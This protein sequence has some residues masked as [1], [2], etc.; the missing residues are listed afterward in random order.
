MFRSSYYD[1]KIVIYLYDNKLIHPITDII[2]IIN[3]YCNT[4][5]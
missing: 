1:L 4:K 3:T 2:E 5:I